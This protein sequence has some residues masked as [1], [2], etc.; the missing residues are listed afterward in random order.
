MPE[1]LGI[2]GELPPTAERYNDPEIDAISDR[3]GA[4]CDRLGFVEVGEVAVARNRLAHQVMLDGGFD[5][6]NDQHSALLNAYKDVAEDSLQ[7]NPQPQV[8]IGYQLALARLWLDLDDQMRFYECLDP[9][10]YEGVVYMLD[11]TPGCD[12]QLHEL[13][14]IIDSLESLNT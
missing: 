14:N 2:G 9:D 3:L 13:I 5:A 7:N 6:Q 10:G 11:S 1:Q 4:L 12:A 8:A